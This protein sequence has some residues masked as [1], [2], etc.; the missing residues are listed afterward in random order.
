L[1]DPRADP[2]ITALSGVL[3]DMK[4]NHQ[5]TDILI[6]AGDGQVHWSDNYADNFEIQYATYTRIMNEVKTVFKGPNIFWTF[7]N[8]DLEHAE[9]CA[10][11][12]RGGFNH[13]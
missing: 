1:T 10:K 3:N 8:N 2:P 6:C 7:G 4:S 12:R 5:D 13:F 11:N 9:P